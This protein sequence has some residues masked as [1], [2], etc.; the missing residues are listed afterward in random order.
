MA[1][2]E[3]MEDLKPTG[4]PV[5]AAA[6]GTTDDVEIE[7]VDDTPEA[8]RNR[9]PL[10]RPV[11]EPSE[12][13]LAAYSEGVQK[14]IKELTHARHD[15]RRAKEA[16]AREKQELE[17]MASAIAEENKRLRAQFAVGAQ[18]LAESAVSAADSAV[19]AAKRKLK[20]AHDA[21]DTDA[22]VAAQEELAEAKLQQ[23]QA[24]S[25]KPAPLQEP[26]PVVQQQQSESPPPLDERTLRW[27]QRNQW[28]GNPEHEEM[29]LFSLGLHRRLVKEGFDPRTDGYFE[30]VDARLRKTF[31]DFFGET[32]S[33][34]PA[35]QPSTRS[36]PV[37][38][39]STRTTGARKIQLTPT[40][41]ALAKKYG[42]TPQQYAA[43]VLKLE[44]ANG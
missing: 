4:K 40:Q 36:A 19:E 16:L 13:E 29:T 14:R 9:K 12:D 25:F 32:P 31:P 27:Q 10:E 18:R 5:A 35:A 44:R 22:I 1:Y 6:S 21:F 26:E 34:A 39:P 28:F 24:K 30:Q 7:I 17:R 11:E 33:P 41:L 42:L 8:D 37:V 2:E 20:E 43:E 3:I 23:Q 38:A 15:E